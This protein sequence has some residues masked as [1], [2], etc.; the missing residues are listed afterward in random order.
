ML[1][2][3]AQR[4]DHCLAPAKGFEGAAI[5]KAA[6]RLLGAGFVREVK[7]KIGAGAWRRDEELRQAY[8]L[9]LTPAGLKVIAVDE[10]NDDERPGMSDIAP[11]R[12]L[13]KM[14]KSAKRVM[15]MGAESVAASKP[16]TV[17][18]PTNLPIPSAPREGTKI[19][20]V[21][22]LLARDQGA[23]LAEIVAAT[24]WL[25]HTARAALTGL[26]WRGYAIER[27]G[28]AVGARA[29]VIAA[30]SNAAVA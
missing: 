21:I 19:A 18:K 30:A 29:Y 17:V 1:S 11:T 13:P 3:A 8:G 10:V 14:T 27:R 6:Q 12:E 15:A 20:Q 22:A 28:R 23:T 2:A 25:P 5:Q 4:R 7:N 9:K 24:G 16:A 26:R